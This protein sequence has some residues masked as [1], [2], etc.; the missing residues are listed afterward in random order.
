MSIDLLAIELFV[1]IALVG[2]YIHR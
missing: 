1:V 2:L